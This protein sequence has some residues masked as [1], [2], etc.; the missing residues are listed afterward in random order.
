MSV[1]L[2]PVFV[3]GMFNRANKK[4]RTVFDFSVT[5]ADGTYE[6]YHKDGKPNNEWFSCEDDKYILYV[7]HG[8][9]L[10]P[11]NC[12]K[13]NMIEHVGYHDMITKF[14]GGKEE[15]RLAAFYKSRDEGKA[16]EFLK[17]ERDVIFKLGTNPA[18]QFAFIKDYLDFHIKNYLDFKNG[19]SKYPDYIGQVLV[20]GK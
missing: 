11:L 14:Y 7:K 8:D 15:D 1:L 19:T 18:S 9:W 12:D 10:I 16:K 20:E 13:K 3:K 2:K 5:T 6:I 17:E 4:M